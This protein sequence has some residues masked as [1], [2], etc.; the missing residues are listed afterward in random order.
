MPRPLLVYFE[1][2][3]SQ[4]IDVQTFRNSRL[5][6]ENQRLE[7][8]VET[9]WHGTLAETCKW[10]WKNGSFFN[11]WEPKETHFNQWKFIKTNSKYCKYHEKL[12]RQNMLS[13]QNLGRVKKTKICMQG[14]VTLFFHW[15]MIF[16]GGW[17]TCYCFIGLL[18]HW[19][20]HWFIDSLHHS[21][22]DSLIPWFIHSSSGSLI[23]GYV[24]SPIHWFID[25]LIHQLTDSSIHWFIDSVSQ[26]RMVSLMS[27]HW[28]LRSSE[29]HLLI[30]WSISQLPHFVA[31]ASQKLPRPFFSYSCFIF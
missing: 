31:P 30:R 3:Y 5:E 6:S 26:L 10:K 14:G 4:S 19:F 8:S 24:P 21:F 23:H 16:Q 1:E 7:C 9:A 22:I 12:S 20:L 2:I 15:F 17:F 28:K 29:Q 13:T 27:C 25:S 18:S 11:T